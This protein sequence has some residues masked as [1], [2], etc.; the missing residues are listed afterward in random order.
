M[1]YLIVADPLSSFQ[2]RYD[3]TLRLAAE[4]LARGHAVDYMDH[5]QADARL[6]AESY[7]AKLPVR[8]VLD[9]DP[10]REPYF[11]LGPARFARVG[12]YDII[13]QRQDPPVNDE[14]RAHASRFACAPAHILQINNPAATPWHSE[15]EL[16]LRYPQYAIPTTL[17]TNFEGFRD[18]VCR[19]EGPEAVAKPMNQCSGIGIEFLPHDAPEA[20]L[21]A[22]WDRWQPRVIVQP[23]EE[24]ILRSGDLRILMINQRVLGQVLRV[25]RAGSKLANLHQG[26][27]GRAFAPT[28]RQLEA[29]H[30]VAA[31]LAP[32]G[33]HL[34]GLD[35]IGDRLSEVNI[36][37]PSAL[38]QIN[39]VM[40]QRTE[41]V[42]IDEIEGLLRATRA[43]ASLEQFL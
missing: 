10:A 38:V 33:L 13:L 37:S 19:S 6:D 17:C 26:A 20:Q 18:A 39:E 43:K 29:S 42:L 36:T 23:F 14:F 3:T 41:E 25:P 34:L 5:T 30:H 4:I 35:F 8:S 7:L 1:K 11:E 27:T 40:N 9:S 24:E 28:A 15:H 32:L 22:Y 16:P 31:D 21:R 12:E 2:P